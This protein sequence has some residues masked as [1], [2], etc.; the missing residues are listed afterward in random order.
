MAEVFSSQTLQVDRDT[1]QNKLLIALPTCRVFIDTS[2]AQPDEC[3]VAAVSESSAVPKLATGRWLNKDYWEAG[4]DERYDFADGTLRDDEV[5]NWIINMDSAS[6][7]YKQPIAGERWED[8]RVRCYNHVHGQDLL[9]FT[10]SAGDTAKVST[11]T[12]TFEDGSLNQGLPEGITFDAGNVQNGWALST[13]DKYAGTY[14]LK[15]G[16][17]D[18]MLKQVVTITVNVTQNN[19]DFSF[20]WLHDNRMW[21]TNF[22]E[23]N[24]WFEFSIDGEVYLR[25]DHAAGPF[26]PATYETWQQF[27]LSVDT[28]TKLLSAGT[29]TFS[30][31]HNRA[32]TSVGNAH[33]ATYIDD[34]EFPEIMLSDDVDA[35]NRWFYAYG[36]VR[37]AKYW[38]WKK[39]DDEDT[40]EVDPSRSSRTT[41]DFIT[42]DR[43]GRIYYG[44]PH[45]V[46]RILIDDDGNDHIDESFGSGR[47]TGDAGGYVQFTAT[48]NI[49]PEPSPCLDPSW[50]APDII[51]DPPWGSFQIMPVLDGIQIRGVNAAIRDAT[52]DPLSK[53]LYDFK[54]TLHGLKKEEFRDFLKSIGRWSQRPSGWTVSDSGKQL[55]P[56]LEV[57]WRP[58]SQATAWPEKEPYDSPPYRSDFAKSTIN[59][60]AIAAWVGAGR[61]GSLRPRELFLLNKNSNK[62]RWSHVNYVIPR[63][64]SDALT[65]F[66]QYVWWHAVG[67]DPP[68]WD[69]SGDVPDGYWHPDDP[70]EYA[71]GLGVAG[72]PYP[73]VQ[74]YLIQARF[75]PTGW[76]WLA[77][78]QQGAWFD[79]ILCPEEYVEDEEVET[80]IWRWQIEDQKNFWVFTDFDAVDEGQMNCYAAR[81]EMST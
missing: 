54:T 12:A 20:W 4:S 16:G 51:D 35:K 53:H 27:K 25:V 42:M 23:V 26:L 2:A 13:D 33:L 44:N 14:S 79:N 40:T 60:P 49:E 17:N 9:L 69:G 34:V 68:P 47:F 8:I 73:S 10:T 28:P 41:P 76:R 31:V 38:A 1:Y 55:V 62:P 67:N 11:P 80:Q 32:T 75:D 52:Q 56:H 64:Y 78:R 59:D 43:Q 72:G 46:C 37:R 77:W 57:I 21:P 63:G 45:Y 30:W 5:E 22:P 15:S 50:I 19:S 24:E 61:G 36:K 18:T 66:P 74:W 71:A 81:T 7:A 39:Q 6:S 65:Q 3:W 70:P 48:T 58:T 29:H